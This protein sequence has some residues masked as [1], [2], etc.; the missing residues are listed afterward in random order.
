M[1]FLAASFALALGV[2]ALASPGSAV[3]VSTTDSEVIDG[4]AFLDGDAVSLDETP[5]SARLWLSESIFDVDADLDAL[6]VLPDGRVVLSVAE[7]QLVSINGFP[8]D[9]GDL[10]IYDPVT[11]SAGMF[12]S[13]LAYGTSVDVDGVDVLPDGDVVISFSHNEIVPA[14]G[15][16]LDGDL[17]RF[18]PAD[19]SVSLFLPESIFAFDSDVDGVHVTGGG[20]VLLS[21]RDNGQIGALAFDDDDIV[22]YD[23]ATGTAAMFL[24][25]GSRIGEADLDAIALDEAPA[26]RNGVDD[27]GD[28]LVDFPADPGCAGAGD[29][30]E[31][32][33]ALACDDGED[34]D[35]DGLGDFPADP[36]CAVPAS[37]LENPA[38]QDGLD[39]DG[40][41]QVDFD[42]G[43]S[44]GAPGLT[45]PDPACFGH[46]WREREDGDRLPACGLGFELALLLPLLRRLRAR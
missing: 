26:C 1:R 18:H 7:D 39:N 19:G 23:P 31:H 34:N 27:D 35:G 8:F 42:G 2:A 32:D 20:R 45:A 9:D 40:D 37:E 13:E 10:V 46:G 14:F 12:L 22:E 30:S 6:D 38:C 43:A 5:G 29:D 25:L 3:I 15:V 4:M 16:V 11:D 44:A 24:D 21:T 33:A 17:I 28:K 41:G 36:G